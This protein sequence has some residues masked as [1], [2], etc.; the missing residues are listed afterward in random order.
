LTDAGPLKTGGLPSQGDRAIRHEAVA[1][2]SAIPNTTAKKN[3]KKVFM[4]IRKTQ[5]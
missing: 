2:P 3:A 4:A 1:T 5:F